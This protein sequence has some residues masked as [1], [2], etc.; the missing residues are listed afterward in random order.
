MR[1]TRHSQATSAAAAIVGSIASWATAAGCV[2]EAE[3]EAAPAL[4]A[5]DLVV[6]ELRGPQTGSDDRGQ[7]VELYNATGD[8]LSLRGVVVS[9]YRLDGSSEARVIV[10]D[11]VN[12]AAGGYV[13][14]GPGTTFAALPFVDYAMEN[15][16]GADLFPAG[17]VDVSARG[18]QI[19]RVVYGTLP[20]TGSYSLGAIDGAAPSATGNDSDLAWCTDQST[21]ETIDDELAFGSPGLENAPCQ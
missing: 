9:L 7:F 12:V 15:D 3:P 8:A 5:G 1:R 16:M 20:P 6:T 18:V 10:R 4:A 17:A 2:V 19:D 21:D 14:L 11:E 13:V